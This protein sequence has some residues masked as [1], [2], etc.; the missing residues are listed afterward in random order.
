M[1]WQIVRRE[2][3]RQV[4]ADG[5]HF[6]QST[7]YHVYAL[8][9]FLHAGILATVNDL[10]V[11][12]G[13][14]AKLEKM[15]N[16]LCLLTR[17]GTGPRF[18]DD[19]G[20]RLFDPRRNRAEHMADPLA[21]GAVLFGREDFKAVAGAL[22]EE[23]LWLL[24]E[25]GVAEF[26]R[27]PATAPA[28]SSAA[29]PAGGLYFLGGPRQQL[30]VD[31]GPQGTS[32]AGHGHA[33]ALSVCLN[34]I[35]R[36]LLIDPGACEYVGEERRL[37]LQHRFSQHPPGGWPRTSASE[38]TVFVDCPPPRAIGGLGYGPDF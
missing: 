28:E 19:D 5:L 33:D 22:R 27:L 14:D 16:A 34:R 35:G 6:E 10:S 9:L 38:R 2:A 21:T 26:E 31:A 15:L 8:D 1:G 20:G 3:E 25:E 12:A 13:F 37:F 24:G 4:Q 23:T 17:A 7:Y 18:G 29:L 32:S 36:P 11:P 30:V